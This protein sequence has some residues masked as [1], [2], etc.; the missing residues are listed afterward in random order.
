MSSV[1][2]STLSTMAPSFRIAHIS[3]THVSPEYNRVN[4]IKLKSF[5]AHVIDEDYDHIV[6]TGDITGQ[7]E[8]RGYRS[9]RRLLR[10]FDLLHYDRL[11]VTIGNH[12]IFGGVHR[13]E[14]LF[15]FGQHCKTTDYQ[16]Q[17]RLFE[18]TFKETFPQKAYTGES[19]FPYV[20]IVGPAAIVGIN[21]ISPFHPLINPVGSNG[22]ITESQLV[23]I[24]RILRHP[25][26][27]DLKKIVL[28]HHHFNKF[29]P[30]SESL[31]SKLY[32]KFESQTL[33]LYG[34]KKVEEIMKSC[35]VSAVLHG[36]T[37]IEGIY[38][39]SGILFSSAALNPVR[40]KHDGEDPLADGRI[41]FNEISISDEGEVKISRRLAEADRRGTSPHVLGSKL[42]AE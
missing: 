28:I 10:Y 2:T 14:D 27:A 25:S 30:Y 32:Q 40:E 9:V 24:E 41:R 18:R 42:T 5:L 4:I 3:D 33:K 26:I 16:G 21:S 15:T 17:I 29:R 36:H 19:P 1:D 11:S 20:K 12:D 37:H 23:G 22:R 8:L 39:V 13:A 35:G 31:G 38:S 7:G 6:I 34:K